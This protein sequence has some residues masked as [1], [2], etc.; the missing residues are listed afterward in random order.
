MIIAGVVVVL[1]VVA[2]LFLGI[3]PTFE[4]AGSAGTRINEL[5]ASIQAEQSVVDRRLSYKSQSAQTEVELIRVAGEVPETPDL[6]SLIINLQ[7]TANDAGLEF[8]QISPEAP[9]AIVGADGLPA[10]YSS[11][12]IVVRVKGKW[13]D[14]IEYVRLLGK[15]TRGVRI[16]NATMTYVSATENTDG[17]V[18]ANIKLEVYTMSVI[19]V[20][21]SVPAVPS[22]PATPSADAQPSQ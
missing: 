12:P 4:K 6:P 10:G 11:L 1:I 17:Y 19:N 13:A 18:E 3:L 20:S 14:V 8:A 15:Y 5:T 16:T 21:Q 22:A 2:A 9:N 7:D